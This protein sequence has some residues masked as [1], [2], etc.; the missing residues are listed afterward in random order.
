MRLSAGSTRPDQGRIGDVERKERGTS[1][2]GPL[3][4]A[5][6]HRA[7]VVRR[8]GC[9]RIDSIATPAF[10]RVLNSGILVAIGG[11]PRQTLRYGH[12]STSGLAARHSARVL[13][14]LDTAVVGVV[15]VASHN[16]GGAVKLGRVGRVVQRKPATVT[17]SLVLVAWASHSACSVD[18]RASGLTRPF[19]ERGSTVAFPT[20]LNTKPSIISAVGCA[21]VQCH[22]IVSKELVRQGATV[23]R[24]LVATLINVT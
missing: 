24:F 15:G 11:R 22:A 17:A 10:R 3:V 9:G 14:L 18:G 19:V 23:R 7:L 6:K 4:T 8:V 20:V 2:V 12:G 21:R 5:A 13:G 1:A 16:L